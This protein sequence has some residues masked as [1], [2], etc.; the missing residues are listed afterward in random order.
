MRITPRHREVESS[1]RRLVEDADLP[2]P[3]EVDYGSD[4][5]VF[6]WHGPKVAVAVDFDHPDEAS[7]DDR[8]A[9]LAPLEK[10]TIDHRTA[11][12]ETVA[13][14]PQQDSNL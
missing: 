5:V 13:S 1:F 10:L 12:V 11:A 6:S 2:E 4:C 3:D 14:A 7:P 9:A 8:G